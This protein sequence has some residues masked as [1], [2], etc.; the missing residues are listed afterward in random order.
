MGLLLLTVL[1]NR[2]IIVS[3]LPATNH[4][5]CSFLFF[6]LSCFF[7]FTPAPRYGVLDISVLSCT[8]LCRVLHYYFC[9]A[10]Y[11]YSIFFSST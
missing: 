5:C 4:L 2:S 3:F 7:H 10:S 8:V 11:E 6:F 9:F 1:L